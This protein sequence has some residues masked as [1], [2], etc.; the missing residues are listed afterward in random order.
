MLTNW[1]LNKNLKKIT[2]DGERKSKIPPVHANSIGD[3]IN[4]ASG[5]NEANIIEESTLLLHLPH[6]VVNVIT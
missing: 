4:Q 6:R 1:N 2:E 3:R 5:R